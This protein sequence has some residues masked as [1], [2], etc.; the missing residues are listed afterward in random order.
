[1]CFQRSRTSRL[2]AGSSLVTSVVYVTIPLCVISFESGVCGRA[3]SFET[4]GSN[5]GENLFDPPLVSFRGLP[6]LI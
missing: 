3:C 2:Y 5:A 4:I 1:M 6:I